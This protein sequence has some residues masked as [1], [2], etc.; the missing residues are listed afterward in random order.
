MDRTS[1]KRPF[2]TCASWP[3]AVGHERQLRRCGTRRIRA[4]RPT[5][6]ERVDGLV[7]VG[8]RSSPPAGAAAGRPSLP[9]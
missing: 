2:L 6:S 8:T 9:A 4:G 1:P 7:W 5:A 3:T